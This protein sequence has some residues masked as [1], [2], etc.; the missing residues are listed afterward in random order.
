WCIIA[1]LHFFTAKP[2]KSYLSSNSSLN[3]GHSIF[4]RDSQVNR[5]GSEGTR[6]EGETNSYSQLHL[7]L[8]Q[9]MLQLFLEHGA[10]SG[11]PLQ[12]KVLQQ[13]R[14]QQPSQQPL[15]PQLLQPQSAQNPEVIS[16]SQMRSIADE[17]EIHRRR[18]LACTGDNE[19]DAEK[20]AVVQLALDRLGQ[21]L[22]VSLATGCLYGDR[23]ELFERLSLLPQNRL[24]N[25]VISKHSPHP[26]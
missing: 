23:G 9:A 1:P 12:S 10:G 22:Q 5:C 15:P 11:T 20:D 2:K 21:A 19:V 8:L 7:A 6:V 17:L 25:I 26:G 18:I 4:G 24:I 3:N 16:A 14:K 13:P